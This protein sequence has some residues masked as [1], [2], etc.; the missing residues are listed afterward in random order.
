MALAGGVPR[1]ETLESFEF[2][3][4]RRFPAQQHSGSSAG[5]HLGVN[6]LGLAIGALDD[7]FE[8]ISDTE[9]DGGLQ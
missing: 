2:T 1:E 3:W 5:E 9:P 4:M 7:Q 6:Q 8:P